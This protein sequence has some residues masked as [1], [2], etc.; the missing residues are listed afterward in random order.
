M[1]RRRKQRQYPPIGVVSEGTLAT[2][3]LLDAFLD[4]LKEYDDGSHAALIEEAEA[5]DVDDESDEGN[6]N[7]I[8]DEL[9]TALEELAAPYSYFGSHEGDGALFG[10]WPAIDTLMEDMRS[11]ELK[12]SGY[13]ADISDHGNVTLYDASGNEIWSVV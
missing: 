12:E 5:V 9:Q 6:A 7:V 2:A 10:F 11:G 8:V 13:R 4:V 1:T 3:D